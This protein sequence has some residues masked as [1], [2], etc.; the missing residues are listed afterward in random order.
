MR[1]LEIATELCPSDGFAWR[2]CAIVLRRKAEK[3]AG[4]EK[5]AFLAE[6]SR[7][8]E[9]AA[10]VD[11][12][13]ADIWASWAHLLYEE[14]ECRA[15]PECDCFFRE[16]AVR[17]SVAMEIA[18][19]SPYICANYAVL[20]THHSL[21]SPHDQ[22]VQLL[23]K[24]LAL[25]NHAHDIDSESGLQYSNEAFALLLRSRFATGDEKNDFL[26][27]AALSAERA[28]KLEPL[29]SMGWNNWAAVLVQQAI[30]MNGEV[31]AVQLDSANEMHDKLDVVSESK[32]SSAYGRAATAALRGDSEACRALL[33]ATVGEAPLD[34]RAYIRGD[35]AFDSV[36]DE[37]WF[38]QLLERL[39]R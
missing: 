36:R 4:Q 5:Q 13:D 20:L 15:E 27:R 24:A 14:A 32:N 29:L 35:R 16:S 39:P 11:P 28:T 21:H 9:K 1:K 33:Q 34:S 19:R 10:Q 2:W 6:A 17:Y 37:E 3:C 22:A 12:N 7:R 38:R 31:R 25:M 26:H 8:I 30:P 18:P 23:D